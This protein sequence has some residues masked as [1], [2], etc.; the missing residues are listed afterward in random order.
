MDNNE[1]SDCPFCGAA[2]EHG[3]LQGGQQ[4]ALSRP[5]MTGTG[6]GFFRIA[7]QSPGYNEPSSAVSRCIFRVAR[8]SA[9]KAVWAATSM[10]CAALDHGTRILHTDTAP[11]TSC[12][13][14]DD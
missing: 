12:V 4:D 11:V 2:L 14:E 9:A 6:F 1:Q 13:R 7:W 3:S 10:A 8:S 5:K